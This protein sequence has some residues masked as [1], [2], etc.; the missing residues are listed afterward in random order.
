M[1][2]NCHL[3]PDQRIFDQNEPTRCSDYGRDNTCVTSKFVFK[4]Q[5]IFAF[6]C[7]SANGFQLGPDLYPSAQVCM[8]P[9]PD[10]LCQR[11]IQ[12]FFQLE[13]VPDRGY[14]CHSTCCTWD[15]CNAVFDKFTKEGKEKKGLYQNGV[16]NPNQGGGGEGGGYGGNPMA[17]NNPYGNAQMMYP[18][19]PPPNSR[20]S[21]IKESTWLTIIIGVMIG[22]ILI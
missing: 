21:M 7:L 20:R 12:A 5:I 14:Q 6:G 15:G 3:S 2:K 1:W 16:Y 4:G 22:V 10:P 9:I 11:T 13:K 17:G 8:D 19:G 18:Y